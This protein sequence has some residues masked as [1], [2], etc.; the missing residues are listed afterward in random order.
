M[1]DKGL[2]RAPD[3]PLRERL[4]GAAEGLDRAPDRTLRE[5]LALLFLKRA[6]R[7]HPAVGTCCTHR[8]IARLHVLSN[9][10]E[11]MSSTILI[12]INKKSPQ[13]NL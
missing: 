4:A 11:G 8:L 6:H 13:I 3:R 5:P 1:S 10:I 7:Q 2:D 9:P 12:S